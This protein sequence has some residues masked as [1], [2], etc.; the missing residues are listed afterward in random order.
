MAKKVVKDSLGKSFTLH[1]IGLVMTPRT[2]GIRLRLGEEALELW[3][4]DDQE[5]ESEDTMSNTAG[6]EPHKTN[7]QPGKENEQVSLGDTSLRRDSCHS[8]LRTGK[9]QLHKARFHPTVGKGSRAHL[10]LGCAPQV[11]ARITGF[12]M[13]K[14]VS[15][16]Q[17][18]VKNENP[19]ESDGILETFSI[20]EGELRN[21]GDSIW[22][23][24]PEKEINVSSM[25]SGFY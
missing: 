16:E 9:S 10:T 3:G 21:Y 8:T 19:E 12:D 11:H 20:P 15:C 25:F 23:I 17:R 24:Y 13:M 18:I 14:V 2:F 7:Q 6:K 1:V 22:V 5:T 4:M